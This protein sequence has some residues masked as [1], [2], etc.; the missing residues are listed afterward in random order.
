MRDRYVT[1]TQQAVAE[2]L[3]HGWKLCRIRPGT[4]GPTYAEWNAQGHAI[5]TVEGFPL[6]WGVGLLHAYSGTC[7]VD[8]DNYP[9]AEAFLKEHG[10]DL[11]VLWMAD[12]AVRFMRGD[13]SRGKL[14]YAMP[15]PR[16]SISVAPF[17]STDKTGKPSERMAL[18]LRCSSSTGNSVQDVLPPSM[19]PSGKPYQWDCGIVGEWR[20][21]PPLPA[22]LEALWDA[23]QAPA[24][25]GQTEIAVPAG[26]TPEGITRWLATQDP[27]MSY[28]DWL[29]VGMKLHAEFQGSNDG[30]AIWQRWSSASPKWD[31]KARQEMFPKWKGF[32]LQGPAIA[33][34]ERDVRQAPAAPEEFSAVSA[35]KPIQFS[36]APASAAELADIV[37]DQRIESKQNREALERLVYVANGKPRYFQLSPGEHCG[38]AIPALDEHAGGHDADAVRNIFRPFMHPVVAEGQ[39]AP[40]TPDPVYYFQEAKWKM[41]H[42]V[43]N[44]G[45]HPGE[46]RVYVDTDGKRRLNTYCKDDPEPIPM[47]PDI[48]ER[49][50]WLLNR[51]EGAD[52]HTTFALWL[53]RF[54]AYI[55][56][57][58]G[59]KVQQAALIVGKSGSGKSTLVDTIP[60]LLVGRRHVKQVTH[61]QLCSR[62]LG[63]QIMDTWFATLNELKM[64]GDNKGERGAIAESLKPLITEPTISAEK[65]GMMPWEVPNRLQIMACS[66]HYDALHI[67]DAD[68]ERRWGVGLLDKPLT[69]AEIAKY[70]VPVYHYPT[71]DDPHK[72][73][74]WFLHYFR[75]FHGGRVHEVFNPCGRPPVTDIK[76]LMAEQSMGTWESRIYERMAER[77]QPFDK[78]IVSPTDIQDVLRGLN[79][80]NWGKAGA[81]LRAAPFNCIEERLTA[82]RYWAWRNQEFWSTLPATAWRDYYA[83]GVCPEGRPSDDETDLL[84][85]IDATAT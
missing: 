73:R 12:D 20:N 66:E 23:L 7:A 29:K 74:A 55:V 85:D 67:E 62:W 56:Q 15:A 27:G 22:A 68:T 76:R 40:R 78:D 83:H 57:N 64:T 19:H 61:A 25:T 41:H 28:P 16:I 34:L 37:D 84:G 4:K 46:K 42:V 31:E 71:K 75:T 1:P 77:H 45:F 5:P 14:L 8:I 65:K 17:P 11:N 50:H 18:E 79:Y 24:T 60:A 59:V 53:C 2:Y 63:G 26:A 54:Y 36:A 39:K 38:P 80:P 3:A 81:I 43:D 52:K 69:P 32:K 51:L 13:P 82:M 33:T 35:E 70:I 6:G 49:F 58:P 10:I 72:S 30:F 47:P 44:F 21:L 48:K 9:V